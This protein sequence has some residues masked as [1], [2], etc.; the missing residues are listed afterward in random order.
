MKTTTRPT[1]K[2]APK[3]PK[4]SKAKPKS[5]PIEIDSREGSGPFARLFNPYGIEIQLTRLNSGDFAFAGCGP[6]GTANIGFERK[7]INEIM[8]CI[9]GDDRLTGEQLPKM[10]EDYDYCYLI[11]EGIWKAGKDGQVMV[12]RHGAHWKT[13]GLHARSLHNY[14]MGL[15][16]RTG[17]IVWCS[18]TQQ[19]TVDFLVDQYRMWQVPWDDH[20]SHNRI[21]APKG[22]P[23]K[24]RFIFKT[25]AMRR[26]E[27]V[28]VQL[29]GLDSRAMDAARYFGSI[30]KALAATPEQWGNI[31]IGG[32]KLGLETGRKIVSAIDELA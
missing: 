17:L 3:P 10:A 15:T 1:K 26:L 31:T 11:V 22:A 16:L 4:Q 30:R 19:G 29:P 18:G 32:R 27:A 23:G 12:C 25:K 5:V 6:Q 24:L 9:T 2:V 28:L 14:L 13:Y 21:Y 20:T 7:T 8:D